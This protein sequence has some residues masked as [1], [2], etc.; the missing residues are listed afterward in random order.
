[1]ST[2]PANK[3]H[4]AR[5]FVIIFLAVIAFFVWSKYLNMDPTP[6]ASENS[7]A[8]IGGSFELV[9]HTG[10]P[11]TEETFYGKYM[12]VYF[13]YTYCPDVCPMDL[14]IMADSLRYLDA[15]QLDQITPVFVTVDPER[16]TVEV[17]A[18]Y[19]K[20]FH[21]D[22]VGLTGTLEQIETIKKAYRVY[23]AKADD[24]ADYLVDHTAY[25]YFM[26]KDGALLQHF[27]HGEDP[28]AMAS[29]MAS[30]IN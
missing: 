12:I 24:S 6:T 26:D 27:N 20:F 17:M 13:G 30:F 3:K 23:A 28:E 11:V 19:I 29:K 25:T 15:E 16:D 1:M 8:L 21:E 14:Q 7:R 2:M 22:L 4:L 18:E 5:L 9:D 10:T